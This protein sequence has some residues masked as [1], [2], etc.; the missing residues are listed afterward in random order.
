MARD[1][2]YTQSREIEIEEQNIVTLHMYRKREL[3]LISALELDKY[4]NNTISV[5][6]YCRIFFI[7]YVCIVL[8]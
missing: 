5:N 7:V 8:Y 3:F 1:N 2:A 4:M 6:Y